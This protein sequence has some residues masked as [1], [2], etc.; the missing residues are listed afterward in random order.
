MR[1]GCRASSAWGRY[2]V[3]NSAYLKFVQAGGYEKDEFWG[4]SG[5]ARRLFVTCDQTSPGPGHWPNSH[6][7]PEGEEEHPV[8]SISYVEAL[9]FVN[10]CN[11]VGAGNRDTLWSL[12]RED[13]WEFAARS[14]Q[15]FLYPWGDTFDFSRCNS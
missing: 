6:T 15:G 9:A 10:W 7:V 12:P 5:S 1:F 11:A 4:K 2:L 14:E 3:T 13:Q 8:S